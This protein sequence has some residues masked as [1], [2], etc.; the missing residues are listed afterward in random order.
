MVF[1]LFW[2]LVPYLLQVLV[3]AYWAASAV[4]LATV[5]DA[6]NSSVNKTSFINDN[7]EVERWVDDVSSRVPCDPDVSVVH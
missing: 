4:Y 5:G 6:Q 7:G 3:I 2:P 1:V